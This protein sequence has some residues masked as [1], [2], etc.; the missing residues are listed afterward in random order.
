M[1]RRLFLKRAISSFPMAV[2]PP[3]IGSPF[4][5]GNTRP[6]QIGKSVVVVGAGVAGLASAR[7]LSRLGFSVTV[8]EAQSTVGGRL[9][10][11]R[12]LGLAFDEG[13]SWI[14]GSTGNPITSL[15]RESGVETIPADDESVI[16]YNVNG[17]V[18]Q[19]G[20]R[21]K[22]ERQYIRALRAVKKNGAPSKSFQEVFNQLYPDRIEDRHWKFMLSAFLEFDTGADLS[23]LSSIDF[24][25]DDE[26]P[27]SDLFITN[28]YDRIA[29]Y[30][31]D[32]LD[33]RLNTTVSG[34]DYTGAKVKVQAGGASKE[35]DFV[36][37]AVP[38]G[39]LKKGI[40]RFKPELPTGSANAIAGLGMGIVNKFMLVWNKPFWDTKVQF[41]GYTPETK[42]HFNLFLNTRYFSSV[43]GLVSF[44]FGDFAAASEHLSDSAVVDGIMDHLRNIYGSSIPYPQDMVRTKWAGN[45][46]SFGAY[47]YA[48]KGI[49]SDAFDTL[50][51]SVAERVFFAGE[52]TSKAFRGTV[53]GAYLSGIREA[54]KI[55]SLAGSRKAGN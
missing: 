7:E 8:L 23:D 49:S 5:F 48:K 47:S 2:I 26:F 4:F 30:L 52:H 21:R 37:V 42:G 17:T 36:V 15:A 22:A 12:S 11:N 43:N 41:I 27:G 39:V 6:A 33:I 29:T 50:A 40:L 20:V 19:D 51:G 1:H 25:D 55:I 31:A 38:L 9:R 18:Y 34:I 13:A 53:H 45:T 44:A 35:A 54:A 10:T 46:N 16:L 24:Y 32:G 28:G 3:F 14:H